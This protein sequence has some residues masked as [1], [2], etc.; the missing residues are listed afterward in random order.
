MER[1]LLLD[2]HRQSLGQVF[3]RADV[4]ELAHEGTD[5]QL[6]DELRG[7]PAARHDAQLAVDLARVDVLAHLHP[8]LDRAPDELARDLR[9]ACDAVLAADD[10]ADDV[11]VRRPRTSEASTST[12]GTPS[13]R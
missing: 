10:G 3:D 2:D 4:D 9:R 13:A 11:V 6:G 8:A 7:T 12:T 5:R 1:R